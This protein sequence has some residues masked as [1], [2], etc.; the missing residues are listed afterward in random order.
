MY[1]E[2]VPV[3]VDP[4]QRLIVAHNAMGEDIRMERLSERLCDVV[5]H[6]P[7]EGSSK[8]I[9]VAGGLEVLRN[10]PLHCETRRDQGLERCL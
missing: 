10:Q 5:L 4:H 2:A 8:I 9:C 3:R 7:E 6:R 1:A